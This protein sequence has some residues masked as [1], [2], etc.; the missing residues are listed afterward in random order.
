MSANISFI[1]D[2]SIIRKIVKYTDQSNYSYLHNITEIS[3]K[4]VL[5]IT[6]TQTTAFSVCSIL[7]LVGGLVG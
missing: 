6:L 2:L 7:V 3:L 5:I 1:F 4:V